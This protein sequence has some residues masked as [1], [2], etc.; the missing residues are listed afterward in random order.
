EKAGAAVPSVEGLNKRLEKE[1]Q[2]I[3][4]TVPDFQAL[5]TEL[6]TLDMDA[7]SGRLSRGEPLR[8]EEGELIARAR[9]A[10]LDIQLSTGRRWHES[11]LAD[12]LNWPGGEEYRCYIKLLEIDRL[13][14]PQIDTAQRQWLIKQHKSASRHPH[15]AIEGAGPSGLTLALTQYQAG[16]RVTVLEKRSTEYD[17]VQVVRLD[18]KWMNMLKFYLGDKYHELFSSEQG[19]FGRQGWGIIREDGFGEIT[20]RYLEDAL[21]MTLSELISTGEPGIERLAE[22]ELTDVVEPEDGGKYR[23]K[24][25]VPIREHHTE[26]AVTE[27]FKATVKASLEKTELQSFTGDKEKVLKGLSETSFKGFTASK[28]TGENVEEEVRDVD[29][30]I[31]AGGKNSSTVESQLKPVTVTTEEHYGVC[32]WENPE[33]ANRPLDTFDDFRQ[34]VVL[35]KAFQQEFRKQLEERFSVKDLEL[36]MPTEKAAMVASHHSSAESFILQEMLKNIDG[37]VMQT[38]C[39]E[40]KGLVYIGMEMP[41][42]FRFYMKKVI[43][44]SLERRGLSKEQKSELMTLYRQAWFQAVANSYGLDKKVGATADHMNRKFVTTFPVSQHRLHQN[45][46]TLSHGD[47][48]LLVTAAGDAATSPHF[49]RYSGLTGA[50][51]NILHLLTLTQAMASGVSEEELRQEVKALEAKSQRTADFVIERGRAFLSPIQAR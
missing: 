25:K 7:L 43:E 33:M 22:H 14:S 44:V 51:E 3:K 13:R 4:T 45:V 5:M 34:V 16:A 2:Q 10:L 29:L 39:F 42:E 23:L 24:T 31:C 27:A 12:R 11:V 1:I 48:Q 40:N 15:V 35:D 30:L 6:K 21:H 38:R 37:E 9:K 28:N 47:G 46:R 41:K 50:R 18:P 20:T 8:K 19:D 49:M 32:T 26:G 36:W 17:R